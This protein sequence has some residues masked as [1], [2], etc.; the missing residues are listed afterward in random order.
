MEERFHG[1]TKVLSPY[2]PGGTT[3]NTESVF[4]I[5]GVPTDLRKQY[6]SIIAAVIFSLLNFR[7]LLL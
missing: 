1:A 5:I 7:T 4:N 2:L 6:T 3:E